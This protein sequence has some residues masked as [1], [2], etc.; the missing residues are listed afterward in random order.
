MDPDAVI[1]SVRRTGRVVIVQEAPMT[2]GLAAEIIARIN[3]KAFLSLEAPPERVTA[4]DIT[5]PLP[6]GENHYY[7]S[8]DRIYHA[9]RRTASF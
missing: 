3:K 4:P 2:C 6:Q 5:V 9:I 8:P 7:I 1:R